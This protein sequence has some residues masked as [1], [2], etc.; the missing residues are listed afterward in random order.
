[1]AQ[2]D[3]LKQDEKLVQETALVLTEETAAGNVLVAKLAAFEIK[4]QDDAAEIR[5]GLDEATARAKRVEATRKRR[6][7]PLN[8]YIDDTNAEYFA[9]FKEGEKTPT[10]LY[11]RIINICKSKLLAWD[12]EVERLAAIKQAG[13]DEAARRE[14][15]KKK[16]ALDKKAEKAEAKGQTDLAADLRE[17]K[18][19]IVV[20]APVVATPTANINYREDWDF[21]V[22]DKA[23]V[24]EKYKLVDM[25]TVRKVVKAEKK[26][27]EIT[28]IRVFSKKTPVR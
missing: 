3:M 6:V 13:I 5:K 19:N 26:M 21:E 24:P 20:A 14:E 9:L 11:G 23:A 22:T 25:V 28:G 17:Q 16:E 18:E 12:Q 7:G 15:A 1:M 27:C 8:S 4:S 10:S 2:S